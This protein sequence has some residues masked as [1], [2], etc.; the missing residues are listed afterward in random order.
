MVGVSKGGLWPWKCPYCRRD[1]RF[2]TNQL[3]GS[4]NLPWCFGDTTPGELREF[5]RRQQ[6][7]VMTQRA[8]FKRN[9]AWLLHKVA[10]NRG[11]GSILRLV[12]AFMS[13]WVLVSSDKSFIH[14]I[15]SLNEYTRCTWSKGIAES[16]EFLIPLGFVFGTCLEDSM[17]MVFL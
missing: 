12:I 10:A 3:G 1:K 15:Y 11:L 14:A 4:L 8:I 17:E 16:A 5:V 13:C 9:D 2:G 7:K 6:N